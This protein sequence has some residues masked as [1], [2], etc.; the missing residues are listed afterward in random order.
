M[1]LKPVELQ[2]ALPRTSEASR[3]QH[4]QQSKPSLDQQQLA[5]QNVKTSEQL[6]TRSSEVDEPFKSEVREDGRN[7]SSD[8]HGGAGG[9]A[10]D[11]ED[12]SKQSHPAEH[13]YKG[14]HIDFSL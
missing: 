2:I 12:P 8:K 5:A 14:K 10:Q 9:H 1:D 6:R 7:T 13:P 3:I 11:S 4:D